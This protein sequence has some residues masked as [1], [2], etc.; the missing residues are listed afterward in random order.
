MC[1]CKVV[2]GGGELLP[3]EAGQITKAEAKEGYRLACQLKVKEDMELEI[4][5]EI[6]EIKKYEC[7]VRSNDNVATFIKELVVDLPAGEK[8]DFR[9]RR[10]YSDRCSSLQR[11]C[12]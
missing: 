6:L 7:T 8:L 11:A 4:P 12:L 2:E 1:K 5:Q 10:L 3:T 9:R